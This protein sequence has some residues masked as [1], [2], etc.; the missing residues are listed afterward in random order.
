M[1]LHPGPQANS[2]QHFLDRLM[3]DIAQA[4]DLVSNDDSWLIVGPRSSHDTRCSLAC[5]QRFSV[6][7]AHHKRLSLT[8]GAAFS[9]SGQMWQHMFGH[10]KILPQGA[11][12]FADQVLYPCR[13]PRFH[14]WIW[15]RMRDLLGGTCALRLLRCAALVLSLPLTSCLS[16]SLSVVHVPIKQRNKIVYLPRGRSRKVRHAFAI[17]EHIVLTRRDACPGIE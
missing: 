10:K 11:T 4:W 2:F 3:P 14:P 6:R 8:L 1:C 16:S 12:V 5:P 15:Q 7:D 9:H 13:V 17:I